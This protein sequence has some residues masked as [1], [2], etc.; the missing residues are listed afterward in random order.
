M[1][2]TLVQLAANTIRSLVNGKVDDFQPALDLAG[3]L[4]EST[5]VS[6]MTDAKCAWRGMDEEQRAEFLLWL[7]TQYPS[8]AERLAERAKLRAGGYDV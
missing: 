3:H 6:R 4:E 8:T 2:R 5:K 7:D 1:N